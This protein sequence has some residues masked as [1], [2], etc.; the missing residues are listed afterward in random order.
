MS[1][2]LQQ[3][4]IYI[5]NTNLGEIA[6][7]W[8][9]LLLSTFSWNLVVLQ[10]HRKSKLLYP[11][12]WRQGH[13]C[14]V[15]SSYIFW[16]W[17]FPVKK[18]WKWRLKI[19]LKRTSY[20]IFFFIFSL[21]WIYVSTWFSSTCTMMPAET[22]KDVERSFEGPANITHNPQFHS[23]WET[24]VLQYMTLGAPAEPLQ[25]CTGPL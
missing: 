19:L 4:Y 9:S 5:K 25:E 14:N 1:K 12:S 15:Y 10:E 11:C 21:L 17:S 8:I 16:N 3:N 18:M 22:S 20:Q 23:K 6:W 2:S 24:A 13:V 7:H